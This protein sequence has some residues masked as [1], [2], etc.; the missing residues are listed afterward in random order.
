MV[1]K[2]LGSLGHDLVLEQVQRR[3][4]SYKTQRIFLQIKIKAT[5]P[6]TAQYHTILLHTDIF[7]ITGNAWALHAFSR[8]CLSPK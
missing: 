5:P 6:V 1:T 3:L 4:G 7:A 8:T 2:Y